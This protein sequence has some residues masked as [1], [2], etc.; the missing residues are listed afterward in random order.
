MLLKFFH[1]DETHKKLA[2][3]L[4]SAF[5]LLDEHPSNP[6]STISGLYLI[7]ANGLFLYVGQSS[8]LSRRIATHLSGKYN[9][10][11]LRI[12]IFTPEEN[13]IDDFYYLS[14]KKRNKILL[15]NEKQLINALKP[16]ENIAVNYDAPAP[17][18]IHLFSCFN[19]DDPVTL[20]SFH[21]IEL[22]INHYLYFTISS[23]LIGFNV[24]EDIGNTLEIEAINK[25]MK[26]NA[27]RYIDRICNRYN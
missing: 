22:S 21:N 13:G 16:I 25:L 10:E 3:K 19:Q 14:S 24:D 26:Y 20:D 7:E 1:E 23:R 9:L 27:S 2:S 15:A 12:F 11:H 4:N 6:G 17:K 5:R 18:P 8:N